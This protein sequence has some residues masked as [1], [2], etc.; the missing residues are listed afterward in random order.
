PAAVGKKKSKKAD[1]AGYNKKLKV[2][3]FD[4]FRKWIFLGVG[5]LIVLFGLLYLLNSVLPKATITIK[6]DT[7][8]TNSD[9]TFTASPNTSTLNK[10][11]QIVPATIKQYKKTDTEKI[12][13]SGTKDKGTKA[14]GAVTFSTSCGPTVPTIPGGTV[15]SS[16]GLNF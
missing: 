7:S 8:T 12:T 2:P 5:G 10:D 3:N 4:K 13:A 16:N 9:V 11:N 6:T 14:G 15:I 1:K